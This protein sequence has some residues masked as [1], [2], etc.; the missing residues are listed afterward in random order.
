MAIPEHHKELANFLR[1]QFGGVPKVTAYHDESGKRTTTIGEFQTSS[2]LFYSTIGECDSIYSIPD[3]SFEFA[4]IGSLSWLPN[5]L[6]SAVFWLEERSTSDFPL[7]CEDIIRPNA[8]STYRHLAFCPSKYAYTTS[9][10]HTVQW[11]LG[12]PIKDS[13]ISLSSD[14]HFN[15]AYKLCPA[16]LFEAGA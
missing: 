3:G 6:A 13:D 15:L 7:I 5:A 12:I 16:W 8:K 4:V 14:D 1:T 2:G 10:G 9:A 11:L